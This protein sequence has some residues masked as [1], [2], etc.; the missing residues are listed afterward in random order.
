[1]LGAN[2]LYGSGIAV[3]TSGAKFAHQLVDLFTTSLGSWAYYIVL[4][5]AFTTMFSTTLTC[6]DA[7][8]RVMTEVMKEFKLATFLKNG[9]FWSAVLAVGAIVILAFF[10]ENMGKMVM[11]AT[12]ISFITSPFLAFLS[13]K[14]V[15]KS[16][17][18]VQIWSM[19]EYNVAIVGFSFLVL[20]SIMYIIMQ[21]S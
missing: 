18:S 19:K 7:M 21:F 14:I 15:T 10:I 9:V 8:P 5:A 1:M 16:K 13:I 2:M 3:E 17:S 12:T 20:F 11:L 4:I 6:F